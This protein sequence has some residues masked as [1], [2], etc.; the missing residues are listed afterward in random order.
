MKKIVQTTKIESYCCAFLLVDMMKVKAGGGDVG[1]DVV[2][3]ISNGKLCSAEHRVVANKKASRMT[4]A[5]Y[6]NPSNNCQIEPAKA[7]LV[8][9]F[10]PPLYRAFVYKDFLSTYVTD[11]HQEVPPLERYTV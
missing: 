3:I 2:G 1:E 11:T 10:S 8:K 7:L 9:V 4:V 6:I 5:S